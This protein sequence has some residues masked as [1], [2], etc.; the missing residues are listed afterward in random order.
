VARVVLHIG[1]HK[2]GSTTIQDTLFHNRDLLR[3]RGIVYPRIGPFAPHHH[4]TTAWID[5]P[6]R[7]RGRRPAREN[8]ATIVKAWAGD[9]RT[10]IVSSEEFSR[11]R[12]KAVD[13]AELRRIVEPFDRKRMVCV[14]RNQLGYMQSI[15]LQVIKD[16]PFVP[17]DAYVAQCLR[18]GYAT[19]LALDYN[20]LLDR[21]LGGFA[22][23]ETVWLPYER[24]AQA[25][26]LVAQFL[27]ALDLPV[28]AQ[29]LAPLP[30]GD[31]NVSPDPLVLW[32]A[33]QLAGPGEPA[34]RHLGR[35]RALLASELGPSVRTTLF[36]RDQASAVAEAFAPATPA[37][38]R[39]SARRHRLRDRAP[40]P[41]SRDRV[42]RRARPPGL[43]RLAAEGRTAGCRRAASPRLP[44]RLPRFPRRAPADGCRDR[45]RPK[46]RSCAG[47]WS[48]S[49]ASRRA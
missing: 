18:T 48:G 7:Y 44:A 3:R 16:N 1:T 29:E 8:W 9:A 35:A 19:G 6:E 31:S 23:S 47:R 26:G 34:L 42:P 27:A 4:L 22:L 33:R 30:G 17:F 37:S 39:G 21:M 2:T 25:G 40:R 32:M 28:E 41:A 12:P 46:A 43:L 49:G 45:R 5:L 38:R 10:V 13:L 11:M 14:L 20:D 36:T 24:A 15:Y